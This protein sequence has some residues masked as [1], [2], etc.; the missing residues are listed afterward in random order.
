[1]VGEI[2]EE[3]SENCLYDRYL[4]DVIEGDHIYLWYRDTIAVNCNMDHNVKEINFLFGKFFYMFGE[5]FGKK[6]F[7]LGKLLPISLSIVIS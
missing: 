7:L 2:V 4:D 5:F 1:M 3:I 6:N